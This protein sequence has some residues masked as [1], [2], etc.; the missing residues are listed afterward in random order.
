MTVAC[1]SWWR[2]CTMEADSEVL[3][4][5]QLE[6]EIAPLTPDVARIRELISGL[7][8]CHHKAE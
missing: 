3:E 2:N 7:E 1:R 5:D 6:D 4:I 8:L